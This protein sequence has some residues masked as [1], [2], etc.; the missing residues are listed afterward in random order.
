M[1][2]MMLQKSFETH[3]I[4][5]QSPPFEN[6]DLFASDR[7]LQDAVAANGAGGQA[8]ALSEFA[9]RWGTAAMFE[10]AR[11]ANEN[12]PKLKSFDTKG[13]RRDE[14]EFHPAY[15][16][17]MAESMKA[18]LHASTWTAGGSRAPSPSE[19]AR[20][21]RYFMVAQVENG[22]MCP[23]TMTRA[24]VGAL[25]VEPAVLRKVIG[26]ITSRTYDP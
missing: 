10:A 25:A 24:C 13:F 5:N 6:V 26:K 14:V 20:A 21:A 12:T 9:R 7:P 19:V 23:I 16:G 18:G 15:H 1:A 2:A 17:F 11:V 8:D 3:D 4:F 22:H